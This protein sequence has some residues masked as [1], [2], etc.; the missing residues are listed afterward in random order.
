MDA[1]KFAYDVVHQAALKISP[2]LNP[3]ISR[4]PSDLQFSFRDYALLPDNG[5][6]N[7]YSV[8]VEQQKNV[9]IVLGKLLCVIK[10]QHSPL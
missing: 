5:F 4:L 9:S 10:E 3:S 7:R 1:C 2:G 8:T 6:E